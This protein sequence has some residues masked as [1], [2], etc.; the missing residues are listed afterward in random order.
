MTRGSFLLQI[1]NRQ[2]L[3]LIESND[4]S[5]H[6]SWKGDSKLTLPI[7]SVIVYHCASDPTGCTPQSLEKE[8][9]FVKKSNVCRWKS[10]ELFQQTI[11]NL[12]P[13]QRTS[14]SKGVERRKLTKWGRRSFN[15]L[16]LWLNKLPG[17]TI[18]DRILT[19]SFD[20]GS[21]RRHN[22]GRVKWNHRFCFFS[23]RTEIFLV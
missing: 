18:R 22:N 17:W 4:V 23:E 21:H 8:N 12:L 16:W 15:N 10:R 2:N 7:T 5:A 9:S 20:L 13:L 19:V 14:G 6:R 11:P 1:C 3:Q